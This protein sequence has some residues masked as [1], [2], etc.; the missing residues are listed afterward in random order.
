MESCSRNRCGMGL[1]FMLALLVTIVLALPASCIAQ[2]TYGSIIGVVA[3][4][5]GSVVPNASV[6]LTNLDTAATLN[7]V[8]TQT[9]L[10]RFVNVPPARYRIDLDVAGFKHFTRSPIALEVQ[11][12]I[13]VDLTIQIGSQTQTVTVTA[14]TPLLQPATSSLGQVVDQRETDELPL[15]GRNPMSLAALVP[16]VIPQGGTS[17]T[18]TGENPFAWGNYQIGGG[19]AGQSLTYLDG[20]PVNSSYDNL[21]ALIPTQDSLQ[22]FKVQ[23]NTLPPEYGGLAGGVINFTTRSG[24][25]TLHGNAWEYLR[26]KV[27]NA[28]T[29]ELSRWRGGRCGVGR[30]PA[31]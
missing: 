7:T 31:L 11:S 10:Y 21:T 2:T 17:Q 19:M 5:T 18:P 25:N 9:G 20:S 27:L 24:S 23:T 3:D 12:T 16:S 15:N 26:N 13:Q 28:N 14:E 1:L 4:T 30:P 22:E 6:V 8:S 29:F